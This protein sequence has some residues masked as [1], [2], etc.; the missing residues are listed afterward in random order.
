[1]WQEC[2][3]CGA[4][5]NPAAADHMAW[6]ASHGEFPPDHDEEAPDGNVSP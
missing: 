2:P 3:I 6:H 1:M 4:I 5:F